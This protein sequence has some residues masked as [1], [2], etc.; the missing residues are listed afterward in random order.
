MLFNPL[1]E[2]QS[3]HQRR[4]LPQRKS[5]LLIP[6]ITLLANLH[7]EVPEHARQNHTHFGI[8]QIL[9]NAVSRAV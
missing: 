7:I 6:I 1:P 2:P 3:N 9:S 8:G 4:L 5:T